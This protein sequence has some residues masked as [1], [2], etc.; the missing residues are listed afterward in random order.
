MGII[1]DPIKVSLFVAAAAAAVDVVVVD[2]VVAVVAVV[3]VGYLV[4]CSCRGFLGRM[5]TLGRGSER[6]QHRL[7][8]ILHRNRGRAPGSANMKMAAKC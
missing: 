7:I 2:V 6:P 5:G 3:V 1:P 4:T 8:S